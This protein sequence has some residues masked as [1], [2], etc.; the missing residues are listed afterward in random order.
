MLT[1][2]VPDKMTIFIKPS[3]EN[4][5]VQHR[6]SRVMRKP[7]FCICK[8]KDADQ[9][10]SNRAADQC[11]CCHYIDSTI[12]LLPKFKIS[13]LWPSSEAVQPSLCWGWSEIPDKFFRDMAHFVLPNKICIDVPYCD[14]VQVVDYLCRW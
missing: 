10:H 11:L 7:A 6:L 4:Q 13:S 3:H 14:S 1:Y 2:S 9:L 8:N 5:G 12:T